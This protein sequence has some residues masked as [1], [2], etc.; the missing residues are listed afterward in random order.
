MNAVNKREVLA[1]RTVA[2]EPAESMP[3]AALRLARC[4]PVN[5]PS[6]A[7]QGL[8]VELALRA[9]LDAQVEVDPARAALYLGISRARLRYLE[10][11]LERHELLRVEERTRWSHR[12]RVLAL[13]PGA[14]RAV[15][16]QEASEQ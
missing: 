6:R 3:V 2:P 14:G 9:D 1:V 5:L 7:S 15:V 13:A 8:W 4:F 16:T 10:D 12:L 11:E